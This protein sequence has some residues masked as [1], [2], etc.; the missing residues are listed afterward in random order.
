MNYPER[1]RH[2]DDYIDQAGDGLR[3]GSIVLGIILIAMLG[4][5]FYFPSRQSSRVNIDQH[6]ELLKAAPAVP[7]SRSSTPASP[8]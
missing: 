3:W 4:F 5:L 6:S 8:R 2:S 7:S 1:F